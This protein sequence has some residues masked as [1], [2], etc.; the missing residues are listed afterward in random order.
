MRDLIKMVVVLT[1]ICGASGLVL[2]YTNKATKAPREYQL[3]KY[4]QEP[5]IKAVLS[6]YD[7]DPIRDRIVIK[8]GKDEK[9]KPLEKNIFPAKK[10]GKIV[11]LA[12]SAAATGY[13]GLIDVMIGLDPGG[14][15]IG[16]SIMTHSET[17][18]L[19]ARIVEPAFTKQ[20]KGFTLSPDLNLSAKGGK[21]DSVSGATHS[22]EGVVEA[23]RK[24]LE[25]F[26][27][28]KKEVG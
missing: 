3:L 1:V 28:V 12:Y 24:A 21:I 4:V 7:N 23:V 9:G 2:S 8:L 19:G 26:P 17:P 25:L 16:I 18:G 10:G 15:V 11:G 6:S 14:K 13:H 22:S 27:K 5:S 20:F